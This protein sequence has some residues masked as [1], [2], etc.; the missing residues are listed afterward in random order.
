[1]PIK[2]KSGFTKNAGKLMSMASRSASEGRYQEALEAYQ[3]VT[4]WC[5]IRH[6]D[7]VLVE[8]S[9]EDA[10]LHELAY[11]IHVVTLDDDMVTLK[12][13]LYG[14]HQEK[15]SGNFEVACMD[16]GRVAEQALHISA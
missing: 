10:E 13:R 14:I 16:A 12:K 5:L 9:S 11:Q 3:E 7:S 8:V 4:R 1:M 15:V 6:A 2:K